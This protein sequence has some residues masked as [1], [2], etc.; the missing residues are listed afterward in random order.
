MLVCLSFNVSADVENSNPIQLVGVLSQGSLVN[1]K[2]DKG[3]DVFLNGKAIKVT[4]KGQFVLGFG[5]D[6]DLIQVLS[7]ERSGKKI[8]EQTL[9]LLKRDYKIQRIEGVPQKMVTPDPS[10]TA[11]INADAYLVRTARKINLDFDYFL[12]TFI[13]P[14]DGLI[15]GVYG[16]QR[17]YNGTPKR[18]HY[19]LDYAAP[20]GTIVYA[21]ASG[22]VTLT[23]NDMYYSGGTMII[24]HGYG[25]S[26]TFLH[27]SALLVE[28]GDRI[29]QGDPIA[30]IGKGGRA[31]GP[32][33]DWRMN[34]FDVRIDPQLVLERYK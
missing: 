15:T 16:S 33:L 26:S 8:A 30:K 18:P 11:R 10:K 27:L 25:V 3:V 7:L 29:K 34:W 23:H 22:V 2:V 28:E 4:A 31:T 6:A 17:V 32:H 14:S 12:E 21:P 1:G 24:D 13:A 5:R 19:G 20:V 9:S